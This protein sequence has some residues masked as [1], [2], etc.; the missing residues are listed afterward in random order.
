MEFLELEL[1]KW[2]SSIN[3]WVTSN[4]E[5]KSVL[6]SSDI[7]ILGQKEKEIIEIS[8]L[9]KQAHEASESL[10]DTADRF[11]WSSDFKLEHWS[12]LKTHDPFKFQKWSPTINSYQDNDDIIMQNFDRVMHELEKES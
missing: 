6:N 2:S 9:I 8:E 11:K 7:E 5:A 3:D 10:F 12:K 4:E 1:L